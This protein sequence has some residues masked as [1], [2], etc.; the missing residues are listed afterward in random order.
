MKKIFLTVFIL[1]LLGKAKSQISPAAGQLKITIESVTCIN[2]SWDGF[3]EFDGHGNEIMAGF[4]YRVY[5]PANP[6]AARPGAGGTVVF[7]S[8]ING[9]VRAG[10]QNPDLGG[11][12]NGDLV[13]INQSVVNEHMGAD[14]II[15]FSPVLWEM[16]EVNNRTV[17]NQ[18][19]LQL[20]NDLNWAVNQPYPFANTEVKI[21]DIRSQ[22]DSRVIKIFD[23]YRYGPALKYQPIFSSILCN[24]N[25]QGN[26]IVGINSGG[27]GAA[28]QVAFPPTILAL[29][30][31]MLNGLYYNNRNS[32][33]TGTSHAEKESKTYFINGVT[34]SFIES[35]YAITTSNGSYTMSLK[36]EF[37]PDASSASGSNGLISTPTRPANTIRKDFPVKN[38][39]ISNTILTVAGNWSGTK[40]TDSGIYP[41]NFGFELTTNGEVMMKDMNGNVAARGI[42]SFANNSITG[43]YKQL[44]SGE[45]F[46][47]S[48]NFDPNTQ[49]ITGTLGSGN[50]F[51]GQGK[52]ILSRK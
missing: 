18:F 34:V 51:T 1:F 2:K 21:W 3:V 7:G 41:E 13:P 23:K 24:G 14:D 9:Q 38:I 42:Y 46:S 52:F 29:D 6:A 47:F 16:D 43:S 45:T 17:V 31:R 25:T 10:S 50:S 26:R 49:K 12:N 48:C 44:S 36:I 33:I 22:L 11:I 19:N 15:L 8:N 39:N 37:T 32:T 30:T 40:T 27:S 5:N 35:T 4:A 20:A 28:C